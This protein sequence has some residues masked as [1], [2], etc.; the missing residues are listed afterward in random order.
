MISTAVL[1]SMMLPCVA[2]A[3]SVPNVAGRVPSHALMHSPRVRTARCAMSSKAAACQLSSLLEVAEQYDCLLLDQFG[4]IHDGATAYEGAVEAV[5]EL[6]RRGKKI[7][8]ISNSSRRRGDTVARLLAMGFGPCVG[9]SGEVLLPA[10]SSAED[11]QAK[12]LPISVVTSG[13]LVFEGLSADEAPPFAGLGIRTLCFGNGAD[14]EE[15]TRECGKVAAPID[16]ADFLLARGLFTILGAGPDLLRE[17]FASYSAEAEREV[18]EAA[19]ARR[20]GGLPLLVANPDTVRPDGKDTPM[21]GMLASR[22]RAMGATD[23]RLVGKPHALIYEACRQKLVAEAGISP[24]EAR[25]VAVG[26]S[27]HHDVLGAANNGVDSIF[28]CSGV[29]YTDLG[30]PQAQ[31]VAPDPEKLQALL[32]EFAAETDGV[33][34]THTLTSFRL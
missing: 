11:D 9:E 7:C 27:L 32:D 15:Y 3:I 22:Y 18:L 33:E 12:L 8:V 23:I 21:P 4:V 26:D 30:I 2:M 17:P 24:D 29:H 31:D 13:D 1:S 10:G 5:T 25:I 19:L 6:Q 16:Q 34:P 14:D 28:I 20:P